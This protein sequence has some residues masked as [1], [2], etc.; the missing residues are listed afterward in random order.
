MIEEEALYLNLQESNT[1]IGENLLFRHLRM[2][3]KTS[4]VYVGI[5]I[6]LIVTFSLTYQ[7]IRLPNLFEKK[8]L[9]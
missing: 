3:N 9:N 8:E 7:H 1:T 6:F 4:N 5:T 2:F